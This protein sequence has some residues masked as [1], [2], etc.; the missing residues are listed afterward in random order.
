MHQIILITLIS[1]VNPCIATYVGVIWPV[2]LLFYVNTQSKKRSYFEWILISGQGFAQISTTQALTVCKYSSLLTKMV[3]TTTAQ[4]PELTWIKSAT[5]FMQW[6]SHD[7]QELIIK[8]QTFKACFLQ[9][10]NKKSA[11]HM[12]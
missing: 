8:K 1:T 5:A 2:I 3:R 6:R 4:K 7:L 12:D 9:H 10:E 11:F